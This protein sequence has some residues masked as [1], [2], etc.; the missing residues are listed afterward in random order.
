MSINP[1]DLTGRTILVTGASSGIGRET[2]LLLSQLNARLILVARNRDRLER[3]Q[4]E[5]EGAGHRVEPFD[6]TALDAVP[7]WI[8]DLASR[9]GPLH[10][11]VHSAGVYGVFP[12]RILTASKLEEILRVNL[13]AALMLAKGFRQKGCH[14]DGGSL[15][16]LSSVAGLVGHA[17][18]SAYAAS[19]SALFGATKSLAMEL[20]REGIRVNCVAPG[21]VATEMSAQVEAQTPGEITAVESAHPLGVGRPRDVANGIAFLLSDAARWI[22]GAT[23]TIDGGYTAH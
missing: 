5:L 21:L 10:G 16:L 1:M 6:V 3:T 22:T 14:A 9:S 4:A 18:L 17:G 20:A 13:S 15:V 7:G 19:K 8:K 12:L 11:V 23:I 2:A